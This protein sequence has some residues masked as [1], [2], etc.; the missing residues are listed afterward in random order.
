MKAV[1]SQTLFANVATL[2]NDARSD[3]VVTGLEIPDSASYLQTDKF[4]NDFDSN[5]WP[6]TGRNRA[7]RLFKAFATHLAGDQHFGQYC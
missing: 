7:L 2:P 6:Q 4:V 3:N 5:G 1:L